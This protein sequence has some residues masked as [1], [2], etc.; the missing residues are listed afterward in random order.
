MSVYI[1]VIISGRIIRQ[2]G[3]EINSFPHLLD[4]SPVLFGRTS[5]TTVTLDKKRLDRSLQFVQFRLWSQ[6]LGI[7]RNQ[8]GSHTILYQSYD[9]PRVMDSRLADFYPVPDLDSPGRLRISIIDLYPIALAGIRGLTARL[10]RTDGPKIFVYT[11]FFSHNQN[12]FLVHTTG[13][14]SEELLNREFSRLFL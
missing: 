1:H 11:N 6:I 7:L 5:G 8:L 4:S 10:E 12:G 14:A 9:T 13:I 3:I 2:V